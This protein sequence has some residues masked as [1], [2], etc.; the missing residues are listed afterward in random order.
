MTVARSK[1]KEGSK[2]RN[3]MDK[4]KEGVVL[5]RSTADLIKMIATAAAQFGISAEVLKQI[6]S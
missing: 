2:E 4:L 1:F 6:F 5:A 3:F